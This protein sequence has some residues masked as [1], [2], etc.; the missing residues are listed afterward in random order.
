M[1]PCGLNIRF[2]GRSAETD[3]LKRNLHP[4]DNSERLKVTAIY[5]LGGVGKTQLAL[6]YANNAMDLYDVI[7]WIQVKN[8]IKMTQALSKFAAKL[9]LPNVRGR[10]DGYQSTQN[11][12]DWLNTSGKTFL[13]FDNVEHHDLLEQIHS[14]WSK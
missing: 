3:I 4:N 11:V 7:I 9:G 8:Q 6:H 13:V 1:I 2:F 5:G 12:N 10:E 14:P